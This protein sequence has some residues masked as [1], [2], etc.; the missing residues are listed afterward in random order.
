MAELPKELR[1]ARAA[2]LWI[3]WLAIFWG[4][5]AAG[6]GF[7]GGDGISSA[8]EWLFQALWALVFGSVQ[9]YFGRKIG[10]DRDASLRS[11]KYL[12]YM[13]IAVVIL[14]AISI[15]TEDYRAIV[16]MLIALLLLSYYRAAKKT[17]LANA[18]LQTT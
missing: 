9:L 7:A 6:L 4:V 3:G 15:I 1:K 18:V 2:S 13:M 11:L 12:S 8:G 5:A 16:S 17:L 10:A 14:A